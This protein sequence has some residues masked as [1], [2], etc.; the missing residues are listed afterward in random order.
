[1]FDS[2]RTTEIVGIAK[3]QTVLDGFLRH[4]NTAPVNLLAGAHGEAQ[5]ITRAEL[6]GRGC[7]LARKFRLLGVDAGDK[8]LTVLPTGKPFL[9]SVFGAWCAGAAIVPVAPPASAT[10]TDFYQSKLASMIRTAE[11]KI[12]VACEA[13]FDVLKKLSELTD[14]IIILRDTEVLCDFVGEPDAPYISHPN[15]LA[16]IQFT[17]GSTDS[18]K[19]AAITH[20]QLAVNVEQIGK[21]ML[22][23]EP[24]EKITVGWLPVHHDM[25]FI[26]SLI[27]SFFHGIELNLIPTETF[28]RN[29]AIW[30]K[31]ISDVRATLSPAPTF[32]YEL[33]A[34]R[35]SDARLHGIDL[36]SWRYAWVGAEPIF[37]K[38]LQKFNERFSKYGLP[39]ATLKPCYGL[40]E[41]TLAVSLTPLADSYKT[42]WINQQSLRE[43]GCAETALADAPNA[44]EITCCGVPIDGT[45]VRI[46]NEDGS[47]AEERNQGK[48]W[49]RGASVMNGYLGD[50]ASPI[51]A[52]GW[53]E[54]GDLGFKIGEEIYITGRAKDLI[55]RGG[56]NIHPQEI[57]KIANAVEGVRMGTAA[58]FSCIR[59]ER[60]REEIVLVVETRQKQVEARAGIIEQIQNE[61]ARQ[62]RIQIDHIEFFAAG[63]IP[64][65]TS[66]KIQRNLTKQMF[67]NKQTI[68][69]I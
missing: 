31:T 34:S 41:A 43:K 21:V 23:N 27:V 69:K 11:P 53:L 37:S 12:I 30:L 17:S 4:T 68:E 18:P 60:G 25:G 32:A 13:V 64:K 52:E 57:E 20:G 8:V 63:T 19:G 7:A 38:I 1:M 15:D 42:V 65:T 6:Y 46:A 55:I 59:H 5:T 28:I 56:V 50:V 67:L 36:S 44:A 48:V 62:G 58:A 26:G 54:T 49:V 10:T 51:D 45:E 9:V 39:E 33:L 40:A 3:P 14:N 61:V 29:P 47:A 16:H 2:E 66:G 35:V 24:M 22:G